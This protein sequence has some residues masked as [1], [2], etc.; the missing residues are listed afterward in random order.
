M[1]F[2]KTRENVQLPYIVKGMD[3]SFSGL[4]TA[5][6]KKLRDGKA[7]EDLCFSLQ[8]TTFAMLVEVTERA[9]A[10]TEKKELLLTGGVAA[11][12]RLSEMLE[13]MAIDHSVSFN[14]VPRNLAG[15]NG[16]MIAWTGLLQAEYGNFLDLSDSQ[17]IPKWRLNEIEI[18][19]M[20]EV[21]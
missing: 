14:V 8:E 9:I 3:L 20:R 12:S 4:L 6:I 5:T 19:W 1:E 18:P 17:I 16:V 13:D 21:E 7:L 10:H 11:N 15:D 2:Q